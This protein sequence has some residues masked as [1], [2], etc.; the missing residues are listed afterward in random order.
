MHGPL[1]W[2]SYAI[3]ALMALAALYSLYISIKYWSGIGV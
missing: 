3:V 1:K 2:A